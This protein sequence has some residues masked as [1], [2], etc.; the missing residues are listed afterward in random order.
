MSV[1]PRTRTT[2][3]E[4]GG[5]GTRLLPKLLTDHVFFV[6]VGTV[7]RELLGYT[8][9]QLEVSCCTHGPTGPLCYRID[10]RRISVQWAVSLLRVST[11]PVDDQEKLTAFFFGTCVEKPSEPCLALRQRCWRPSSSVRQ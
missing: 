1:T 11:G 7:D 10:G 2:T 5:F 8:C 4:S 6:A 9:C 3:C